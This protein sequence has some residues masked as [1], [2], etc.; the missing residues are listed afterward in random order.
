MNT[1]YT[2]IRASGA[3]MVFDKKTLP[4]VIDALYAEFQTGGSQFDDFHALYG[5]GKLL[6][7]HG[8][9]GIVNRVGR[10][11]RKEMDAVH[12]A[13]AEAIQNAISGMGEKS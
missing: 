1:R 11:K 6:V 12:E 13:Y 4:Q 5:N 9:Q 10:M 7:G 8:L 3:A 2:V